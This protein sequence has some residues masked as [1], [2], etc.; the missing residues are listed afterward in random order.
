MLQTICKKKITGL[1]S[2][3]STVCR[4]DPFVTVV[5]CIQNLHN[6]TSSGLMFCQQL[7]LCCFQTSTSDHFMLCF[8]VLGKWTQTTINTKLTLFN[9]PTE[10]TAYICI[11]KIMVAILTMVAYTYH[12]SSKLHYMQ[13]VFHCLQACLS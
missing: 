5:Q 3:M 4:N 8:T 9:Q 6:N 2:I 1:F 12:L 7:F 10:F 13:Y 11:L